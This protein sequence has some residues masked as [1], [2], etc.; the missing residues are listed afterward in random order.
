MA[1]SLRA[2]P[3]ACLDAAGSLANTLVVES[4]KQV[5]NFLACGGG[6]SRRA[7]FQPAFHARY[8]WPCHDL[9]CAVLLARA[10]HN[11][12]CDLHSRRPALARSLV[13][14]LSAAPRASS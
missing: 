5:R 13:I 4:S 10:L 2:L 12:A 6:A 14:G 9:G 7:R 8:S 1:V 3:T 11:P